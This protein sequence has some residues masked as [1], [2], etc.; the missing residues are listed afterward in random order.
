MNSDCIS[1]FIGALILVA[2]IY[3]V[4]RAVRFDMLPMDKKVSETKSV[5]LGVLKIMQNRI[6]QLQMRLIDINGLPSGDKE[7]KEK[8]ANRLKILL[9]KAIDDYEKYIN[10]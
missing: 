3:A 2:V 1:C 5:D 9:N 7:L 4:Y 6:D 10:R 8:L